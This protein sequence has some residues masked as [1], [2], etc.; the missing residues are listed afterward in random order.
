MPM[1]KEMPEAERPRE[2][3]FSQGAAALSNTELMALLIGSGSSTSDALTLAA[4]VLAALAE[5][6][7][8]LR[9]ASPEELM[10]V[11]GIGAATAARL[12]AAAELGVRAAAQKQGHRPRLGTPY[13]VAE[14]FSAELCGEKQECLLA[15]MTNIKGEMIGTCLVSR[16]GEA[17]TA[18][19]PKDVF[20]PA[21]K[22]GA[23]GVI[24]VHN[25]PSGN[26]EP[27]ETDVDASERIAK[28]GE[29]IGVELIDH[30]ILGGGRYE[31][32]KARK[33]I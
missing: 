19:E 25:H 31:S 27:S 6:E 14:R 24:L 32:L 30:V 11:P 22:R 12:L 1:I 33:L 20:R 5:G 18:A 17:S 7:M 2:K 29:L 21:V 8:S 28:A 26:P 23:A 16:G 9:D 13:D 4:G 15:V 3:L 10:A